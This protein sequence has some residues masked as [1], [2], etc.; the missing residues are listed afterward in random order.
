MGKYNFVNSFQ[1]NSGLDYGSVDF[2]NAH[3]EEFKAFSHLKASA[4]R[5]ED[6]IVNQMVPKSDS[7][8]SDP[9]NYVLSKSQMETLQE[10]TE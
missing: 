10:Q 2:D 6:G 8:D 4:D 1:N 3:Q 7:G 9:Q 5:S